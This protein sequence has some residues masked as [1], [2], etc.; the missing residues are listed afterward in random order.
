MNS[1]KKA[2]QREKWIKKKK[3]ILKVT[4]PTFKKRVGTK[5]KVRE[6]IGELEK[7]VSQK[8]RK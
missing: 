4:S 5:G 3:Q 6:V 8:P 2:H 1:C 7:V